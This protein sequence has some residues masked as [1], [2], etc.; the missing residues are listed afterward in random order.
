MSPKH[1][2]HPLFLL[3]FSD[4][5]NHSEDLN[6]SNYIINIEAHLLKLDRNPTTDA[7]YILASESKLD[8]IE[9]IWAI[10]EMKKLHERLQLDQPE[11]D[12]NVSNQSD[13]EVVAHIEIS[14]GKV[15]DIK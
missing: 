14:N 5:G 15:K 1:G 8:D 11:R 6:E 2:Q 13:Y 12:I 9:P 7:V 3:L 10:E 4:R